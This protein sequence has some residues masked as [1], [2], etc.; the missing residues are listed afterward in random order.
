MRSFRKTVSRSALT[1]LTFTGFGLPDGDDVF[2]ED[3]ML[4]KSEFATEQTKIHSDH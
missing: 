3:H 1:V 2:M 4:C